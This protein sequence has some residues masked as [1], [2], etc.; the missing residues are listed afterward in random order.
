MRDIPFTVDPEQPAPAET[1]AR[2][3]EAGRAPTVP[4]ARDAPAAPPRAAPEAQVWTVAQLTRRIRGLLEESFTVVTVEGEIS[5][6]RRAGSGHW[7]FQ[8]KDADAQVRCVMFRNAAQGLRFELEDGLQVRLRG[9][10]TVY[11]ARGEYQLQ[12]LTVEPKGAGAL[13]LAFEQLKKRLEAEGL[14]DAARKQPLPFLPRRIGIVT[15]PTGAAIRDMLHVL[16]RRFPGLPVLI[17]PARVQGE[18]AA[19]EVAAGLAELNRRAADQRIDVIIVGRGGGSIEDLWAFNEE[20]VARAI[21]ASRVPVISAV[22]HEIDFTI[23][24]FVADARAPTPSAA[25]EIAVPNRADLLAT[26]GGLRGALEH[27]LRQALARRRERREH[28]RAR[29]GT[30]E[31]RLAQVVQRNDELRLRLE[32]A[33]AARL[34]RAAERLHRAGE[35]L[36]TVRPDRF[37]RLHRATVRGLE[38]RLGPALQRH[39]RA[40]RERWAGEVEL[41]E[42]LSPLTVMR[43]GYGAVLGPDR[44]LVTSVGQVRPGQAVQVRLHDGTLD[45]DVTGVTR[46]DGSD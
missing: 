24:D 36:R 25:A 16:E 14:F 6:A 8:L 15:S 10:L 4:A 29:L 35:A 39:V 30:P 27:H 45:A 1:P 2:P 28:L 20:V 33:G 5:N 37:H 44:R 7:Y 23:A 32:A 41:L 26:V 12:A 11:E 38:R 46:E 18:G 21:F 42:S 9:R 3:A 22:G 13:Q 19:A 31:Q 40:L 17:C 43:R 34:A